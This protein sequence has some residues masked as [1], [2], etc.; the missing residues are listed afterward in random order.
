MLTRLLEKPYLLLIIAAFFWGSNFVISKVVIETVPPITLSVLRWVVSLL[1]ILPFAWREFKQHQ[2]LLLKHWKPLLLLSASG[3]AGF[4][5]FLYIAVQYTTAINASLVNAVAPMF[6]I[7]LSVIWLKERLMPIQYVGVFISLGGVLWIFSQGS[8]ENLIALRFNPGDIYVLLA[9]ISWAIYSLM[10]KRRGHEIPKKAT[11]LVTI[12]LGIIILLP[13]WLWE[14]VNREVFPQDYSINVWLAIVY[15]GIFPS[16]ISFICWNEG[17]LRV[18]PG[19]ASH[20]LYLIV[21]F[22]GLMALFIGE[23]YTWIQFTGGAMILTGVIIASNRIARNKPPDT[24]L[25]NN[26]TGDGK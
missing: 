2:A 9:V 21:F 11:F 3:V 26:Q 1:C 25:Q 14:M 16:V 7:M 10:M 15:L 13:F 17:V 8:L 12:V 18:G 5:A 6:I 20:F 24:S 23:A 19:K 4:N 22:A